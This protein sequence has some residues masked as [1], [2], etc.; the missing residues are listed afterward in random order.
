MPV[1][2]VEYDDLK[3]LGVDIRKDKLIEI[4]PMMGSDIEEFDEES[5]KVEFF[6]NRPDQL[7]VEGVARSLK[8]FLGLEKGLPSYNVE[9]SGMKVYVDMSVT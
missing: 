1:I 5:V 2:T 3:K 6:P 8:G 9:N 7:S 4:L